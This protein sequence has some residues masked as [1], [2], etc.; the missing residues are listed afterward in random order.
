MSEEDPVYER[1][2]D[3]EELREL[4]EV[5]G[6]FPVEHYSLTVGDM[7]F[8]RARTPV[9]TGRRAEI[10][11]VVVRPDGQILVHTKRFYPPGIYRLISGGIQTGE[12]VEQALEREIREETGQSIASRCLIGV[13]TYNIVH[14]ADQIDFASYVYRV[15]VR[16][17]EVWVEDDEEEISDLRWV[18]FSTLEE[19]RQQ[20]RRVPEGWQD[21][22][23][24]RALGH[25]FVLRHRA[26]CQ[27]G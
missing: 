8:E 17:S 27:L 9:G 3:Q 21:W 11:A 15:D 25:D 7:F 2:I 10:L 5:Y 24:Y 23:E 26:R 12:P 19:I 4:R 14:G 18:P 16:N 22:G 1:H 20:L 13:I 6:D